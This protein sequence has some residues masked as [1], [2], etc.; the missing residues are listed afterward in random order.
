[1]HLI[2]FSVSFI[3][4]LKIIICIQLTQLKIIKIFNMYSIV[5]FSRTTFIKNLGHIYSWKTIGR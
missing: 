5:P 1:M 4:K 2:L 3:L